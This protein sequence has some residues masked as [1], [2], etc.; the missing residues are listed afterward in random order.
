M[1][2][3]K[4][5]TRVIS[6]LLL[7]NN[8]LYKGSKFKN[9][10]YIGDPIN[11][12]KLFNE[13]ECDEI[14][15]LD[16]TATLENK[17]P[18]YLLLEK[19]AE[20]A[21]MPMGYGGG[22]NSM[23]DIRTIFSLGYEKIIL[24]SAAILN[25]EIVK[26]AAEEYGSQ[27]IV[28]SVDVRRTVFNDYMIYIKSGTQKIKNKR[29][30]DHIKNMIE[31]GA[32]EILLSNIDMDGCMSGYDLRLINL[33]TGYSNIPVI[34]SC[35]AGSISD[36]VLARNSKASAVAAGS[37]FVFQGPHR[38][39]LINYPSYALLLEKIGEKS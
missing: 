31:L 32:G 24:N 22:L 15:I 8:G 16:I 18:N 25:P 29:I 2:K 10:K 23:E 27:S 4:L 34:A 26:N 6:T 5:T 1:S 39:V 33:V 36:F 19:M 37:M 30:I 21:F 14:A 13:K 35:G 9:H 11:T 12:I 7:K 20:E 3:L 17:K 38:A 28:V